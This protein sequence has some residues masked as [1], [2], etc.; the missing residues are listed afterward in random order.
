MLDLLAQ[1]LLLEGEDEVLQRA[2]NHVVGAEE[3]V[4]GVDELV[5]VLEQVRDLHF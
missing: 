5:V 1:D 3:L 2:G 4:Y